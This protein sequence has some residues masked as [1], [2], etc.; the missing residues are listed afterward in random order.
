[1]V[2]QWVYTWGM[3]GGFL[4]DRIL[5]LDNRQAEVGGA[6]LLWK[7]GMYKTHREWGVQYTHTYTTY[8]Q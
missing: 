6:L 8:T 3:M 4:D 5:Q 1:M 7:V 2:L